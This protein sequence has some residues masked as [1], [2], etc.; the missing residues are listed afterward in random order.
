MI[1]LQTLANFI[2]YF[3]A[4]IMMCGVFLLLY[5]WITPYDEAKLIPSGN[6][7]AAISLG[8]AGIGFVI[9]LAS[10]IAHSLNLP[11]MLVWGSVA[12]IAQLAIY[13]IARVTLPALAAAIGEDRISVG[14]TLASVSLG[15]GVLNAACMTF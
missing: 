2:A 1:Y 15:V 6:R 10:T 9:P 14:I 11:D 5:T 4:S 3:A 12:M 7:A 8:G 13:G